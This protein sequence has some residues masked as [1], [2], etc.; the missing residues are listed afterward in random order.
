MRL[1][2]KRNA[3]RARTRRPN[4]RPSTEQYK[5][6]LAVEVA[7]RSNC[8]RSHVGAIVLLDDRI[9]SAGYNGTVEGYPDCFDGGCPRCR[10]ERIRRGE[11]LDRCVCVHAEENTLV[12]AARYGISVE[13]AECYV[14]HEP[15]LSCTKLLIQAHMGTIVYLKSYEYPDETD[16]NVSRKAMRKSSSRSKFVQFDPGWATPEVF[17]SWLTRLES[18]KKAAY[19]YATKKGIIIS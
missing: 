8:L 13:G 3:I 14:T 12:S 6:S 15:C 7:S 5:M 17:E 19:D 18:M 2:K 11:E 10:D 4:P 16:H 9:R 1:E